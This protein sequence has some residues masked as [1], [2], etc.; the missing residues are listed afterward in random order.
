MAQISASRVNELKARIKA[1][2]QRRAHSGSVS[3]YGG[4]SYDFSTIPAK[5][6]KALQEHKVKNAT[7]LNAINSSII[8]GAMIN[9]TLITEGTMASMEAFTTILEKR[10]ITDHSGTDCSGGC[11]GMCYGCVGTCYDAC[12]GCTGCT[13]CTGC[14]GTCEGTCSDSC[15]DYCNWGCQGGCWSA[16]D[17]DCSGVCSFNC[18][19]C[20]GTCSGGCSGA[21]GTTMQ[22]NA[23]WN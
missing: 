22:M 12:S 10:E 14:T 19:G 3:S 16:C 20:S 17:Y 15:W 9:E 8:T 23:G 7:P 2:C 21:C 5:G 13:S 4:S 1:E 6:V 18:T 11:T